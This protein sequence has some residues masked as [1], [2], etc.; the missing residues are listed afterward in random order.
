MCNK[1][2]ASVANKSLIYLNTP[3]TSCSEDVIGFSTH[4]E[5]LATAIEGGAQMIALTSPFGAGKSS[6]IEL[7]QGGS[8]QAD[9][10]N[11]YVV[12]LALQRDSRIA[13]RFC[14]SIN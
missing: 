8:E 14:L 5:K 13:Q 9:H 2:G 10:K 1:K 3:I 6:I 11:I 4:V 7:L 12:T